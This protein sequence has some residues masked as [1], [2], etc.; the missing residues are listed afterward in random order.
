MQAVGIQ[1]VLR[2]HDLLGV[3]V[4]LLT[5]EAHHVRAVHDCAPLVHYDMAPS[6]QGLEEHEQGAGAT[7]LILVVHTLARLKILLWNELLSLMCCPKHYSAGVEPSRVEHLPQW[8]ACDQK[9]R[10]CDSSRNCFSA[11]KAET[12]ADVERAKFAKSAP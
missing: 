7:P 12:Q 8:L 5:Q 3:Q 1:I 10:F 6:R 11:G 4:D 9:S 2:E